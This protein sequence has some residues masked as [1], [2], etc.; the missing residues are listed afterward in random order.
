MP[1]GISLCIRCCWISSSEKHAPAA[2]VLSFTSILH[3]PLY[4]R[5]VPRADR[6]D[7]AYTE[8]LSVEDYREGYGDEQM[9]ASK[10]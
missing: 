7:S 8:E 1:E 6:T 9:V 3:Y 5:V 2:K 4:G 10:M